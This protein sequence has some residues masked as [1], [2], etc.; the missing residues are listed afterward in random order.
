MAVRTSIYKDSNKYGTTIS[1]SLINDRN[2]IT[3]IGIDYP[4]YK[5]DG[6]EGWFGTTKTTL[7]SVKNNIKMLMMTE[8]GE[9]YL[10]PELG[11]GLRKFLFEPVNDDTL[12]LIREDITSTIKKWLPFVEIRNMEITFNDWDDEVGKNTLNISLVFSIIQ[13]P[14]SLES[15]QVSIGE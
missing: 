15:I 3:N 5:S 1:G 10:Q 12:L 11:L 7:T 4:L 9:R 2:P 8:K 14:N 6:P 13:D